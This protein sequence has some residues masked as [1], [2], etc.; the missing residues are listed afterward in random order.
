V[1]SR[2]DSLLF[3]LFLSLALSHLLSLLS[4]HAARLALRRH[5]GMLCHRSS[6][7]LVWALVGEVG[8]GCSSYVVTAI[9]LL[10]RQICR[11]VRFSAITLRAAPRKILWSSKLA[12]WPWR[13][14]W[15]IRIRERVSSTSTSLTTRWCTFAGR[16]ARPE[17]L[18]MYDDYSCSSRISR[19]ISWMEKRAFQ[20]CVKLHFLLFCSIDLQFVLNVHISTIMCAF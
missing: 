5:L 7:R 19:K 4:S 9:F 14:R 11:A 20:F 6:A 13:E 1:K 2:K 17:W 8:V 3:L 18:K 15:F 10:H 12:K 16:T